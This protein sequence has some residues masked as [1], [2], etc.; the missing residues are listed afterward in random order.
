MLG[1]NVH[2][3][4]YVCKYR[5]A[6]V[7][8]YVGWMYMCIYEYLYMCIYAYVCICLYMDGAL[9]TSKYTSGGSPE[10]PGEGSGGPPEGPGEGGNLGP[11]GPRM[12]HRLDGCLGGAF[13]GGPE[14]QH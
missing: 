5:C 10:G 13:G 4:T 9:G 11:E 1:V 14:C 7:Y 3:C 2:I 12:L 6:H 8:L